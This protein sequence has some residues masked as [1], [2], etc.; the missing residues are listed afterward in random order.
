[1]RDFCE[2]HVIVVNALLPKDA[3]HCA[4][5]TKLVKKKTE[6]YGKSSKYSWPSDFIQ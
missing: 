2:R 1:M 3:Y 6:Q 5:K 4:R